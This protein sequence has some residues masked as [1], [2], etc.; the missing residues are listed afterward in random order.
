MPDKPVRNKRRVP[1]RAGMDSAGN[2]PVK[3]VTRKGSKAKLR[4][5]APVKLTAGGG[6]SFESQVGAW[7]LLQM[8][9]GSPPLEPGVGLITEVHFQTMESGV[10]LDDLL[11]VLTFNG[12]K[13]RCAVSVKSNRQ[14]TKKGFPADF[15]RSAWEQW[16]VKGAELFD[17]DR[18]LLCLAVARLN[19]ELAAAWA[20]TLGEAQGGDPERVARRLRNRRQSATLKRELFESLRCPKSI[21]PSGSSGPETI[22]M[23]A[24]IRLFHF[25]F[26]SSLSDAERNAI[27]GCQRVLR[28]GDY[29]TA[30]KLWKRLIELSDERRRVGGVF[31]LA[32][33][34]SQLRSAF[35]IK[36]Q[37]DLQSDWERIAVVSDEAIGLV[38]RSIGRNI[39]IPRDSSLKSVS[40]ELQGNA[41]VAIV[42]DSGSGKS[43]LAAELASSQGQFSRVFWISPT[44]FDGESDFLV[45]R[46]LG[47]K[48]EFTQLLKANATTPALLVMDGLERFSAASLDR[49]AALAKIA[50]DVGSWRVL[51]TCQEHGWDRVLGAFLRVD[52]PPSGMRLMAPPGPGI[53]EL[54]EATSEV[55]GLARL[56][57]TSGLGS[58]L[59]NLK[60]LD[61]TVTAAE[62]RDIGESSL[63]SEAD[64]ID[65]I[66]SKW[67]GDGE[68]RFHRSS[69]LMTLGAK[70]ADGLAPF[71]STIIDLEPAERSSLGALAKAHLIREKDGRIYFTHD[72]LGDWCRLKR[73]LAYNSDVVGRLSD[74]A[75][76]PRWHRA[77]RLYAQRLIEREGIPAWQDMFDRLLM[78]GS[79]LACDSFLAALVFVNNS[80]TILEAV[81]P[82]LAASNGRLLLRLIGHFLQAATVP[83][84]RLLALSSS[85]ERDLVSTHFRVPSFL[86]WPAVIGLLHRHVGEVR[87]IAPVAAAKVCVSWLSATPQ[88]FPSRSEAAKV[89]LA[90]AREAQGARA[91]GVI[92]LDEADKDLFEAMLYAAPDLPDEVSIVALEL[93]GRRRD[94]PE[95]TLRAQAARL[96]RA[97]DFERRVSGDAEYAKRVAAARHTFGPVGRGPMRPQAAE[98]PS[99]RVPDSFQSAV[100]D[101]RALQPLMR[102]RPDVAREVLLAAC[103]DEPQEIEFGEPSL[104]GGFGTT[105]WP[106]GYP[107]IYFRGPFY[108]F[109][110]IEPRSG[111]ETI[112][113]LVNYATERWLEDGLRSVG[114]EI[115]E[116]RYSIEIPIGDRTV[117]WIGNPRVFGWYR[118][119]AGPNTVIS[120]LMA[121]EKWLY[122]EIDQS[123]DVSRWIEAIFEQSRSLAFA[124]LLTAV[125]LRLP[126]LLTTVLRPLLGAWELYFLQM[127]LVRQ[128]DAWRISMDLFGRPGDQMYKIA[129]EWH[130]LPHRRYIWRVAAIQ[131]MLKSKELQEYFQVCR[132]RWSRRP[133]TLGGSDQ[134]DILI[135]QFDPANYHWEKVSDDE[136]V[137]RCNLPLE[138]QQRND[139]RLAENE[140]SS[141]LSCFPYLCRRILSGEAPLEDGEVDQFWTTV[142]SFSPAGAET[143]ATARDPEASRA[144]AGGIAVLICAKWE[145]LRADQSRLQ[146]CL[147]RL[148]EIGLNPPAQIEPPFV[149]DIT[150]VEA[151]IGEAAVEVMT[152]VPNQRWAR[153]LVAQSVAGTYHF[154]TD[155]TMSAAFRVRH[156]I[157]DD[158]CRLLNLIG[159]WSVAHHVLGGYHRNRVGMPSLDAI[160][161]RLVE[162][163]E[164]GTLPKR[165]I[166]F[167]RLSSP[168]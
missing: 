134:I 8:L 127:N 74:L 48:Q 39:K 45:E 150:A 87:V 130:T 2:L 108:A 93:C 41:L 17:K 164:N 133:E 92:F 21:C 28:Y 104:P 46:R 65:W 101:T 143:E 121:L 151:F 10:R 126:E 18:D 71:C 116:E 36:D 13:R 86:Y 22:R 145:W 107:P 167:A 91:E 58:T 163:F 77:I 82:T 105:H 75:T 97:K 132:A 88:G 102:V 152:H 62:K 76:I 15:V 125:G 158:F 23:L 103:I 139:A 137:L 60:I 153:R 43:A 122:D 166:Q 81:W 26:E 7:A 123:K 149:R 80:A 4:D 30:V 44:Y 49:A 29:E 25:D 119:S 68:D 51:L 34:V 124:G 19:E 118:D 52:L 38:R 141:L 85:A 40:D 168:W 142:K 140:R 156:G 5:Q 53:A 160:R 35:E 154:S 73:L 69:L 110:Q 66:W 12:E 159:Y 120:A 27:G 24:S 162:R 31:D 70:E 50:V 72:L 63:V 128:D 138:L 33:L 131:R 114:G 1:R 109:L 129:Y 54:V 136:C 55:P 155:V 3:S 147:D 113:R 148:S 78:H 115:E 112:L 96:R 11:L 165:E 16:R 56:L 37:P 94:S 67:I 83:D 9:S 42:G 20:A 47:I 157:R 100:L 106:R 161:S 79:T 64:V 32:T 111:L 99:R 6:F 84:P 117:R 135:A 95:I 14:V 61:W 59:S 146:W 89:A 90:V 57:L 98:G 144:L